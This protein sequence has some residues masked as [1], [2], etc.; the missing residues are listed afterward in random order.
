MGAS[1]QHSPGCHQRPNAVPAIPWL[2]PGPNLQL[3]FYSVPGYLPPAGALR[4]AGTCSLPCRLPCSE[5]KLCS[6]SGILQS[7]HGKTAVQSSPD[8]YSRNHLSLSCWGSA[9]VLAFT[10]VYARPSHSLVS[11]MPLSELLLA[12]LALPCM[13]AA[14][15]AHSFLGDTVSRPT[16]V[17]S[18]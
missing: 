5:P 6:H 2:P 12:S 1:W 13:H 7:C 17:S 4:A 18:Q 14:G 8:C 3:P 15:S 11:V 16:R 10:S 9:P